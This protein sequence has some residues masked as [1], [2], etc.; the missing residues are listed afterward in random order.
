MLCSI[1]IASSAQC[2]MGVSWLGNHDTRTWAVSWCSGMRTFRYHG[3][4]FCTYYGVL[5]L[6]RGVDDHHARL[7]RYDRPQSYLHCFKHTPVLFISWSHDEVRLPIS[8]IYSHT[9]FLPCVPYNSLNKP[10]SGISFKH[11]ILARPSQLAL[12][13]TIST[14]RRY[15]SSK[16][17]GTN[18]PGP[19]TSSLAAAFSA[20]I[21]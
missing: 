21:S 4:G 11:L 15:N 17:A 2:T 5:D 13:S 20:A 10:A 3:F 19:L 1:L 12:S 9:R 18:V 8:N 7:S 6:P 16:N 14:L